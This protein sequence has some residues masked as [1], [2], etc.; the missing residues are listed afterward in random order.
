MLNLRI[1]FLSVSNG[2]LLSGTSGLLLNG[3]SGLLLMIYT[4]Y[5][6]YTE[7]GLYV[8]VRWTPCLFF[9]FGRVATGVAVILLFG[10]LY[11]SV[12]FSAHHLNKH[13]DP[14]HSALLTGLNSWYSPLADHCAAN[15]QIASSYVPTPRSASDCRV[16]RR[17]YLRPP[18]LR[19]VH[20]SFPAHG[21]SLC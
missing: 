21:S 19:T 16:V 9:N 4:L 20:T 11:V 3:T 1:Q 8:S 10:S 2:H 6:S 13:T 18:P 12:T 15:L 5:S 17:S 14:I 7:V